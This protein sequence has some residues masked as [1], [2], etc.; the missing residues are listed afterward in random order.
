MWRGGAARSRS[1]WRS[2]AVAQPSQRVDDVGEAD[3]FVKRG[4]RAEVLFVIAL[5]TGQDDDRDVGQRRIFFLLAPERP[6]IHH[7]HPEVEQDDARVAAISEVL[8]RFLSVVR[9]GGVE[10]L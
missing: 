6:T 7:R 8:E 1:S 9:F 2:T 10:S 5:D 4:G 3:R